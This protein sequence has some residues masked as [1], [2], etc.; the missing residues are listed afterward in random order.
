M[1]AAISDVAG[2]DPPR[3][4]PGVH[5]LRFKSLPYDLQFYVAAHE[6]QREKV[7]RRAQNEAAS[8]RRKLAAVAQ[9]HAQETKTERTEGIAADEFK[10]HQVN[11]HTPA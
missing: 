3:S 4:W 9:S 6:A 11:P 2:I 8:A 10:R 7:L 1:A 5:K